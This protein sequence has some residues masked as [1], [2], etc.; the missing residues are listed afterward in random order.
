MEQ[1]VGPHLPPGGLADHPVLLV[2]HVQELV[3]RVDAVH[4]PGRKGRYFRKGYGEKRKG[5]PTSGLMEWNGPCPGHG[6]NTGHVSGVKLIAWPP[7]AA[8]NSPWQYEWPGAACG[9][10]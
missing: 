6:Q 3:A 10:G 7:G 2:D 5:S 9:A 4:L 8:R 1:P